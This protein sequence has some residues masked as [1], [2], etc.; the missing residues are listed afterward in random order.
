MDFGVVFASRVGDSALVALAEELGFHQAWFYDS[1]MIYSDVYATL[2]LA[3]DRTRHIRLATGVAVPTTR[4]A[5][6][7]AHSIATINELA[8]GRVELGLGAGNTAR[9]TMG[10]KPIPLA[11]MKRE[12]RLIRTLLNGETGVL[13]EEGEEHPVRF[14]HPNHG[15]INLRDRIPLTLSALGPKMLEFCG[16]EMDAHLTWGV[17]PGRLIV[18]RNA[19]AAAAQRAG[20]Q[21]ASIPSKGIYPTAVLAPGETAASPRIVESMAPFVTN[22]LHVQMEWG[23]TVMPASP[24]LADAIERYRQYVAT[25]PKDRYY[26]TLHE[27][28]LI[29]AR[30]EALVP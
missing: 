9:L 14:L 2:A 11:R 18:A 26:L 12:I 7:I 29:Y 6:V 10:L 13:R 28:H 22:Y 25:L 8:P 24:P 23:S 17:S 27:G 4:M 16:A 1:Q 19:I 15:F 20:R 21:P 5:P 3:A 30:P